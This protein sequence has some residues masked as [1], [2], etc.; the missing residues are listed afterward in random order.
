MHGSRV[1]YHKIIWNVNS[2]TQWD[3]GNALAVGNNTS[4]WYRDYSLKW[5][6]ISP[7]MWKT[8]EEWVGKPIK[9]VMPKYKRVLFCIKYEEW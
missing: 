3:A 2:D 7:T 5:T 6:T 8:S 9:W 4:L 1:H